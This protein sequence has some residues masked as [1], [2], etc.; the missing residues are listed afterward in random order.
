MN[1]NVNVNVNVN[2]N[3]QVGFTLIELIMVIV[4]L[5]ILSAFAL[6]R[7]A[8]LSGNA[9]IAAMEGA[10]A[11]AKSTSAIVHAS[12]LAN[13][14]T[15]ATGNIIMEGAN[16]ATVNGYPDA[17]GILGATGVDA[18]NGFGISE[19]ANLSDYILIYDTT[20]AFNT[21]SSAA[22]KVAATSVLITVDQG[23]AD[24]PCFTYTQAGTN[25]APTFSNIGTLDITAAPVLT[26]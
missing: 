6:P 22:S 24:S 14:A 19:A 20:G 3:K 9:E 7:F 23:V 12:A 10:Y 17:G 15:A 13:G 4:I 26:C 8:D 21:A 25:A 5:G 1:V 11:S 2:T 18:A 16:F